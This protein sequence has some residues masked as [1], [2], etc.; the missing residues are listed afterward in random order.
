[1]T[2]TSVAVL[3]RRGDTRA[4]AFLDPDTTVRGQAVA[5]DRGSG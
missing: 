5:V 3:V 2:N 1:M 4:T